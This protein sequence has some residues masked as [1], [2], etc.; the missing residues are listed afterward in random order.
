MNHFTT[1]LPMKLL[2]LIPAILA[3]SARA[4]YIPL[5]ADWSDHAYIPPGENRANIFN[6]EPAK[7]EQMKI[8]G[9]KHAMNYPV[10]VTGLLIPY[11]PLINF[12]S[13]DSQNPLKQFILDLEKATQALKVSR[14]FMSG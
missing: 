2:L 9:Y 11:K 6:L 13:A 3:L 8:A 10:T 1:G 14:S 4:E 12:F 7:L 5:K